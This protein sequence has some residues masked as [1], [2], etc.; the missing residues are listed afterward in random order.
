MTGAASVTEVVVDGNTDDATIWFAESRPAE[1]GRTAVLRVRDDGTFEEITPPDANVRT[2]VHEYGGGAWWVQRGR[3][4][5]VELADQ[6]L[7]VLEPG[8][9]PRVLT[10]DDR[11]RFADLRVTPDDQWLV[12]VRERHEPDD[13]EAA[14][15]IVA[16]ALDGSG[17]VNV[18]AGGADFVSNPRLSADGT[19][20]A[21][22]Q[23]FHPNMPW[24]STELWVASFDAGAISDACRVARDAAL[25]QPE[26]SPDALL[27]VIT[28]RS[29]WWRIERVD[30]GRECTAGDRDWGEPPWVF[31]GSTYAFRADGSLIT[32]ADVERALSDVTC[33]RARGS[34]IRT[35]RARSSRIRICAARS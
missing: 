14:N 9:K 1:R 32:L 30:D 18:L 35:S 6:Q 19:Q 20:L 13:T 5:Y 16:I 12:C 3:L 26:W 7:R 33:V 17:V 25:V 15:A 21:W 29:G 27:H 8:N 11:D 4:Y 23:W 2:R 22:L 24:D 34:R 28:D 31:G 10:T